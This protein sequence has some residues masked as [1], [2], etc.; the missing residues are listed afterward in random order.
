[1]ILREIERNT[2]HEAVENHRETFTAKKRQG[3]VLPDLRLAGS[4]GEVSKARGM[5]ALSQVALQKCSSLLHQRH[6]TE[7][8]GCVGVQPSHLKGDGDTVVSRKDFLSHF[9][10]WR[11]LQSG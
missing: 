9:V 4:L 1:M 8:S 2:F 10:S 11:H 7:K 6:N 3:G 5:K